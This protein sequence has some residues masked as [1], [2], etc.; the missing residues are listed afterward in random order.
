MAS[1][2][3]IAALKLGANWVILPA[4]NT[5]ASDV[6]GAQALSSQARALLASHWSVN[7]DTRV[8]PITGAMQ[9]MAR[10][11]KAGRAEALRRSMLAL[12]DKGNTKEAHPTN[13]APFK[14][15]GEGDANDEVPENCAVIVKNRTLSGG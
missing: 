15:V 12:I 1:V 5:A 7:S 14:V 10:D 4:C 2:S 9:E 6:N 13:W 8:K 11:S 3:E